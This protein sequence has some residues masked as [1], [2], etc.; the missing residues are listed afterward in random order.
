M[1]AP[2]AVDWN[3]I[4]QATYETFQA[5]LMPD[6]HPLPPPEWD[7]LPPRVQSA[8]KAVAKVACDLY[9]RASSA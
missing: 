8:W 9:V 7:H 5:E 6:L 4:A 2:A 1:D 3:V